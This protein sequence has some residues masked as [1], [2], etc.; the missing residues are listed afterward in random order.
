VVLID[1]GAVRIGGYARKKAA[2]SYSGGAGRTSRAGVPGARLPGG[3]SAQTR[4]Q[5]PTRMSQGTGRAEPRWPPRAVG[6]QDHGAGLRTDARTAVMRPPGAGRTRRPA[7]QEACAGGRSA[8]C[9]PP[10]KAIP[11]LS[12]RDPVLCEHVMHRSCNRVSRTAEPR[13]ISGR[14]LRVRSVVLCI[15]PGRSGRVSPERPATA[16]RR[17]ARRTRGAAPR[18]GRPHPC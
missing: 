1:A 9:W 16:A 11:T 15:L 4:L 17:G 2:G 7:S 3:G 6:R 13:R 10:F 5:H 12:M 8:L 18:D 14:F